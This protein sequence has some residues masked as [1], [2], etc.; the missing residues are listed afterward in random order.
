MIACLD[1]YNWPESRDAFKGLWRYCRDALLD[2]GHEGRFDAPQDLSPKGEDLAAAAHQGE[3]ILGQ[4]CGITFA[5][6]NHDQPTY[7]SLGAFISADGDMPQGYYTSVIIAREENATI[8]SL[9]DQRFAVNGW[10]SYSGWY[11]LRHHLLT[12]GLGIDLPDSV[13]SGAHRQ[14]VEMVASGEAAWAAIDHISWGMLQRIDPSLTASV[15]KIDQ[16]MPV[17]G[18]PLVTSHHTPKEIAAVLKS[19]LKDYM[20]SA[21]GKA[22][23]APLGLKGIAEINPDAYAPLRFHAG[24]C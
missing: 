8:R 24:D 13:I 16:T 9:W 14:S 19:S 6:A 22:D 15:Y 10:T 1:M 17:P 23:F 12:T 21:E 3:L 5:R 11:G 18:L 7:Q 4:V 2:K 20:A